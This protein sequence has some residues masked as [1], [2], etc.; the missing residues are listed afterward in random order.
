LLTYKIKRLLLNPHRIRY[1]YEAEELSKYLNIPEDPGGD[2]FN[3]VMFELRGQPNPD[4]YFQTVDGR[5]TFVSCLEK[6]TAYLNW[7]AER[8]AALAEIERKEAYKRLSVL[9]KLVYWAIIAFRKLVKYPAL[10]VQQK[11]AAITSFLDY[12][13]KIE[14]YKNNV[15]ENFSEIRKEFQRLQGEIDILESNMARKKKTKKKRKTK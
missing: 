2:D 12:R 5:K 15:G 10:W 8:E 3:T 13:V 7:V 6:T 14:G 4:D 11:H 9:G 1:F